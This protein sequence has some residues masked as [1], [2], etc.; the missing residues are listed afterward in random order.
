MDELIINGA[1]DSFTIINTISGSYNW[2]VECVDNA[3]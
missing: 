2:G 3:G 1:V